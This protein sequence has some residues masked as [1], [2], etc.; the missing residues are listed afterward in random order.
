MSENPAQYSTKKTEEDMRRRFIDPI[1]HG[2]NDANWSFD[3]VD[4]EHP[5]IPGELIPEW[6]TGK[7]KRN[8]PH[9]KPDYVLRFNDDYH[10]GIIEAK[11]SYLHYDDGMQQAIDYAE[12]LGCKF[13]YATNGKDIDKKNNFGIKEYDFL[14]RKY[15]DRGDFPALDELK[16]RLL[17]A[18]DQKFKERFDYLVAPLQ[19]PPNKPPLRYYQKAAV[20]A[21]ME[22]INQRKKKILLNLATGTGKNKDCLCNF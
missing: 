15:S 4:A 14:T 9:K 1:L 13:A 2:E 8:P 10:I 7:T 11:S 22:A 16:S 18:N 3:L 17:A 20:N 6:G 5:Y 12:D 19:R 21:A